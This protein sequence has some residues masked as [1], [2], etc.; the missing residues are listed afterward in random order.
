MTPIAAHRLDFPDPED[1]LDF[2]DDHLPRLRANLPTVRDNLGVGFDS[3][4]ARL[5]L[6]VALGRPVDALVTG[7]RSVVDWGVALFQRAG[8]D[9]DQPT[10]LAID[11]ETIV[12]PG[13]NSYFANSAPRW[14]SPRA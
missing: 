10:T 14:A 12:V 13:G 1:E 8:V 9:R 11:G 4:V 3:A 6:R 5:G 2:L 7:M